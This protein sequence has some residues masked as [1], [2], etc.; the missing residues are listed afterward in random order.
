MRINMEPVNRI[1]GKLNITL[2]KEARA[3]LEELA[4]A[5]GLPLARQ[6]EMAIRATYQNEAADKV[7]AS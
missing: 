2:S 1:R 3:M 7:R 6:I 5:K 4:A